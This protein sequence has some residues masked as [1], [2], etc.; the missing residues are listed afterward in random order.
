MR[1]SIRDNRCIRVLATEIFGKILVANTWSRCGNAVEFRMDFDQTRVVL[2][3]TL[4]HRLEP[5]L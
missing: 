2:S 1:G 4:T 5:N 3:Q